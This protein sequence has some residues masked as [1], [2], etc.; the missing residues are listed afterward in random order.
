MTDLLTWL[1]NNIP[2]LFSGIGV[3]VITWFWQ[4]VQSRWKE[5]RTLSAQSLTSQGVWLP[6]VHERIKAKSMLSRLPS[7]LLRFVLKPEQ[8][9]SN[10]HIRLREN[11]PIA[12]S[13]TGS[14]QVPCVD[15]YFEITNL[16]RVDL[17]LDRLLIDM[18]F[19]QPNFTGALLRRYS[20]P[21]GQITKNIYFRHELTSAQEEQIKRCQSEGVSHTLYLTGYFLSSAGMVEVKRSIPEA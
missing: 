4:K 1:N 17:I 7:F 18:W 6:I 9:A 10:I 21:A 5:Q 3:L 16:N 13:L 20:I 11:N 12:I 19:G 15:I 14:V 2:W 8:I